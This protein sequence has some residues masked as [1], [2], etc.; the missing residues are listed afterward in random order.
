M[1][2]SLVA[3]D[4]GSFLPIGSLE[5][6][7]HHVNQIPLLSEEEEQS[8][9]KS[10]HEQG[11]LAAAKRLVL[12]HLRFVVR[13]ARNYSG[14]GLPQADLIQEGNIGLLKAVKRFNPE[15]GVR[16]VS[17]AIH[18]IK[19]E[20]QEY[21]LANWSIVKVAT[22]KAQ[23]TLFFKLR[24]ATKRLKWFSNEE[25]ANVATQLNVKPEEVRHMEIRLMGAQDESLDTGLD[26]EINSKEKNHNT[27][28][29]C[30]EDNRYNPAQLLETANTSENQ[31]N[32]LG[33]AMAQLNPRDR[34]IV[35]QRWLSEKKATLET[36]AEKYAVSA[37]RIRQ[38]EKN[39]ISSLKSFLSAQ[40]IS[41]IE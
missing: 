9:A 30:L 6:Y 37:E 25:I 4:I 34:D 36:L 41:F 39:A 10:L 38:L 24:R 17:Y 15:V 5:A 32:C 18:W 23:R 12:A 27:I 31:E 20:I 8:L 11:N 26:N 19:A 13:I 40:Q 14:Y 21:I 1:P 33:N 2:A 28:S 7:I 29:L 22:T 3:A 16:L 35:T